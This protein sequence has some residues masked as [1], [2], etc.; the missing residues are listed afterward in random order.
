VSGLVAHQPIR[1]RVQAIGVEPGP[2]S[3]EVVGKAS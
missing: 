2:W 3:A 1:G